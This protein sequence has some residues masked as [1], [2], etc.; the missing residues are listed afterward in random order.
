MKA[1]IRIA[2]IDRYP[3]FRTGVSQTLARRGFN[4]IAEGETAADA[5]RIA[6]QTPPDVLLLDIAVDGGGLEAAR[7]I[8]HRQPTVKIAILTALEDDE[9]VS[10]ALRTGVQGY[11]LKAVSGVELICAVETIHGGDPYITQA[12]ASRMLVQQ[13]TSYPNG[14]RPP[15]D[16]LGLTQPEIEVLR[17]L[18]KGCTNSEIAAELGVTLRYT[19]YLLATTYRKMHVRNRVAAILQIQKMG[20]AANGGTTT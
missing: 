5:C 9:H 14:H 18:A 11:V 19:K 15:A 17:C 10:E 20:L 4:V 6:E 1:P 12:L 3:L 13:R 7:K 8:L 16:T 2:V